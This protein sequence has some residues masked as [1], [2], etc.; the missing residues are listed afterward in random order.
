VTTSRLEPIL[1]ATRVRIESL[2]RRSHSDLEREAKSAPPPLD[3][4]DAISKPGISLVAEIKRQSPSAGPLDSGMSPGERAAACERGGARA[5]SVLTEPDFFLGSFEDLAAVKSASSVPVLRK[6]FMI[7]PLQVLESRAAGADAVL[8]IVA[9]VSDSGLLKEM[10]DASKELQT[11]ALVEIHDEDEVENAMA[12]GAELIGINQRNLR[13]FEVDHGLAARMRGQIPSGVAVIAE[14][15]M[16]RRGDVVELEKA[17][18]DAVL[19]GEALMRASDPET[20][21]A[22]LLGR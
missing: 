5:L 14:S 1:E 6:D 19:V 10:I 13:S 21:V 11:S 2:R 9:A 15:G 3:F 17:G 20:K 22:E 18:V 12:A 8:L 7:D 4:L 16:W